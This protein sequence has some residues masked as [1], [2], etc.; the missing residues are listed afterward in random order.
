M[1]RAKNNRQ[2]LTS[3]PLSIFEYML[4]FYYIILKRSRSGTSANILS[5]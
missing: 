4:G 5:F 2:N 3:I 1:R